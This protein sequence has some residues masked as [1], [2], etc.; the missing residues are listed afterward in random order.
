MLFK[1]PFLVVTFPTFLTHMSFVFDIRHILL[2]EDESLGS[3]IHKTLF[4]SFS[5]KVDKRLWDYQ[6]LCSNVVP[7]E[8]RASDT[9][10]IT[11]AVIQVQ[12]SMSNKCAK[13][14]H[15]V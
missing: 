1:S 3:K 6:E 15:S 11:P 9:S 10:V 8:N 12:T 2:F 4:Q 14:G 13:S 5:T 7:K